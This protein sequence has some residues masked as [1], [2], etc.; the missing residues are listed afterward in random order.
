MALEDPQALIL[1]GVAALAA[2]YV[3]RW[4]THPV[5]EERNVVGDSH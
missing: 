2:L 5:S 1:A 3:V 4:K